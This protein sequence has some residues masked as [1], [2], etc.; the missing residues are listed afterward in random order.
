MKT[1]LFFL[2]T[3]A[4]T[5]KYQTGVY[6]LKPD[7]SD[8]KCQ[9]KISLEYLNNSN[10]EVLRVGDNI[11]LTHLEKETFNEPGKKGCEYKTK[12]E[13]KGSTLKQVVS[14]ECKDKAQNFQKTHELKYV[15]QILDYQYEHKGQASAK[16]HCAYTKGEK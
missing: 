6:N 15:N 7:T 16:F 14:H 5:Y 10:N 3:Q 4:S 8:E 2:I 13:Q 12:S 9:Q 11:T 1:L